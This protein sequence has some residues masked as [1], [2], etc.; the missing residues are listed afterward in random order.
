MAWLRSRL[1]FLNT[2]FVGIR[3][4]SLFCAKSNP[5]ATPTTDLLSLSLISK[6]YLH[7]FIEIPLS[8]T[9]LPLL[10]FGG[11]N[12]FDKLFCSLANLILFKSIALVNP[13]KSISNFHE[14]GVLL[15]KSPSKWLIVPKVI[16]SY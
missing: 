13:V 6:K 12:F 5:G 1:Y 11:D 16:N 10:S 9:M 15:P 14:L 8:L 4:L 3:G 7:I 2:L